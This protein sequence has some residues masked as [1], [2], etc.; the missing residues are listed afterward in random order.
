MV[1]GKNLGA[2]M[3]FMIPPAGIHA[4]PS[5]SPLPVS[6]ASEPRQQRSTGRPLVASLPA[7]GA[8]F[9][10]WAET[11]GS[12]L[13]TWN[14]K[15]AKELRG[16]PALSPSRNRRRRRLASRRSNFR[17]P[18]ARCGQILFAC[19]FHQPARHQQFRVQQCC[20]RRPANHIVAQQ[21]ELPPQHRARPHPP[22]VHGHSPV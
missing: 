3:C 8:A 9:A 19:R 1:I 13:V 2:H 16:A 20:A 6:S 22:N 11:P 10:P 17:L 21:Y 5:A 18:A 15:T 14:T 4:S 7:C 12:P